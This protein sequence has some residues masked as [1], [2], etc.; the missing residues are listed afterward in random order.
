[1]F[2][3][4]FG[5]GLGYLLGT[6]FAPRKGSQIREDLRKKFE[7][8]REDVTIRGQAARAEF[9]EGLSRASESL[10]EAKDIAAEAAGK[11]N[12]NMHDIAKKG[13]DIISK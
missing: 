10:S 6:L 2:R 7:N 1:M 4:F 11:L 3:L 9:S 8:V 13:Q 12:E 5:L